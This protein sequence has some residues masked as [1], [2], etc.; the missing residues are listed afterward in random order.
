M[1]HLTERIVNESPH[2][3][4]FMWGHH[5]AFRPPF[6]GPSCRIDV[7]ARA[8]V[9]GSDPTAAGRLRPDD[10]F[11]WPFARSRSGEQVDLRI[12]PPIDT[13]VADWVCLSGFDE[14]WYAVTDQE[15]RVGIGMA[16]DPGMFPYLWYWQVWGGLPGYPWYGR[17]YNYALEPWTSWPDAGLERAIA[18]GT[19]MVLPGH[20]SIE[21]S[22]VA[23]AYTGLREVTSISRAGDVR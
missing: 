10:A 3:M 11:S 22:L 6:L 23:V 12:V 7:G 13:G 1:L 20:G 2:P 14:G 5:P 15:R 16:W 17:H 9:T 19:A 8:G 4:P 18:N 21:T